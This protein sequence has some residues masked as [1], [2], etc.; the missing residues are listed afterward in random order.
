[1]IVSLYFLISA[2]VP[3]FS[4]SSR[5]FACAISF[6]IVSLDCARSLLNLASDSASLFSRVAACYCCGFMSK[7]AIVASSR[8]LSLIDVCMDCVMVSISDF[9]AYNYY[10]ISCSCYSSSFI[11]C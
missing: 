5:I 2:V 11:L 9:F 3:T 8:S 10:D 6:E 7:I 1:M 4:F